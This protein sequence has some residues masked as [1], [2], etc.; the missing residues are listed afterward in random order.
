MTIKQPDDAANIE[1]KNIHDAMNM[2]VAMDKCT[3]IASW[4]L[5]DPEVRRG[6][7]A[8]KDVVCVANAHRTTANIQTKRDN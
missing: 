6:K 3:Q 1:H 8:I 4:R 2:M 5:A 7:E